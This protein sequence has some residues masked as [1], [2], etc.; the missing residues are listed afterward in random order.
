[1]VLYKQ[2]PGKDSYFFSEDTSAWREVAGINFRELYMM[3]ITL[4]IYYFP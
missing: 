1:M 3:A 4:R 2:A